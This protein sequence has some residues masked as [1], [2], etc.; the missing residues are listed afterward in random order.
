LI[1]LSVYLILKK[2]FIKGIILN[3]LT[4]VIALVVIKIALKYFSIILPVNAVSVGLAGVF[5]LP[6]VLMNLLFI[7]LF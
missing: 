2:C 6:G 5:G 3:A 1:A 7:L 4:G